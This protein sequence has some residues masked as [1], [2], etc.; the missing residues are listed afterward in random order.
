MFTKTMRKFTL[1]GKIS[2][3]TRDKAGAAK[4][5]VKPSREKD[6]IR[7]DFYEVLRRI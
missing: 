3:I 2:V 7:I 4:Q 5:H 1:D 6:N